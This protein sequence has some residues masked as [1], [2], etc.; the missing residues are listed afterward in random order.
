MRNV[1]PCLDVGLKSGSK[2]KSLDDLGVQIPSDTLS[3]EQKSKVIDF[4]EGW[5]HVFS[6]GLTDLGCT[7]KV[8][9]EIELTDN[10]PFKKPYRRIPPGMIE[11]V[12]EHLKDMLNAGAI[13]ESKSPFSSNVVLVRKK[14]GSLRFC[15]D[16]RKL[17]SRTVRDAYSLP[18]VEETIDNHSGSR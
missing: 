5:K 11:E 4:L 6:S 2:N 8:E 10:K 3:S 17:N 13:R 12:R 15:I 9:H 16:F 14:D 18:R 1:D 7:S